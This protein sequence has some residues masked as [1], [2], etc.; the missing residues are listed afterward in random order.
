MSGAADKL[1]QR[2]RHFVLRFAGLQVGVAAVVA[3]VWLA[4]A[5]AAAARAALAGGLVVAL[6]NVIFG[7][8][9]FRPGVAP[10]RA[11]ARAAFAGEALKWLWVGLALWAAFGVAH[12]APLPL[13][14]GLIAAQAGFWFGVALIR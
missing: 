11:L 10:V 6:G 9:L 12:L 1:T 7:W 5:G 13:V 3:A 8:R 14:C 4:A 2:G